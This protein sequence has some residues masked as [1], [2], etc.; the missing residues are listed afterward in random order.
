M[1]LDSLLTLTILQFRDSVVKYCQSSNAKLPKQS[2]VCTRLNPASQ[3]WRLALPVMLTNLLQTLVD[4]VDV[5]MVGR[6]G[7]ISIAAVGISGSIRMLV[8]VMLLSVSAGAMSLIAQAKGGRDPQRMSFVVRQ[9]I[10][11]GVLLSV[12]LTVLGLLLARPILSWVNSGGDPSAVTIGTEY[13]Q[14]LFAGTVFLVLNI[15]FNRL[16]QGAGDTLTPLILTG[17]LNLL[18]IL[19]NYIFMFGD[20]ASRLAALTTNCI[21]KC[22]K[23]EESEELVETLKKI[24]SIVDTGV[25]LT[26]EGRLEPGNQVRVKSGVFAGYEGTVIRREGKT[27][28]SLTVQYLNQGVSVEMDEGLL[29]VI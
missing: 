6:L 17:G 25:P 7:P 4:V 24:K 22:N 8:L 5:F 1:W 15:V 18:N 11:S 13:L 9:A 2:M 10:S 21:N 26:P 12:I 29:E 16:M 19:L 28:F 3:V 14:V 20:E 27:R 23:V